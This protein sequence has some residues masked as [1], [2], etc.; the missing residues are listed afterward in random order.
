LTFF[1]LPLLALLQSAGVPGAADMQL[2]RVVLAFTAAGTIVTAVAI[3]LLPAVQLSRGHVHTTVRESA[4]G[5][6]GRPLRRPAREL[7]IAS[8]MALALVLLAGAGLL[9]RSLWQLQH[10][11]TGFNSERVLTFETAVPTATYAEGDQIRFYDRFY[12]RIRALSGVTT[13]GAINILPLSANYDSRGVQIESAPVPAGQ[14]PS[15]QA[16]SI[17]PDYF[18]AMRIRLTEGRFFS[19]S[20]GGN[21]LLVAIVSEAMARRYWPGRSAVGQRITFN[22]GIPRNQQQD[23]GGPGSREVIGVV[24]DVKHLGLDEAEVPMFYTPQAQQPSYHTMTLVVRTT[25]DAASLTSLIRSELARQDPS[26]PLYRA[27]T[28]DEVLLRATAEARMQAWLLGIF[29]VV[30]VVLAAIGVY[31]VIGYV[32]GQRTQEIAVRLALGAGQ[33][34]VL[35]WIFFEGLR[36][37]SLG[38]TAGVL[39]AA[40][41]TRLMA[42]ML[43]EISPTDPVTYTSV[44]ALLLAIACGAVLIPARR[45]A[46]VHPMDAL[47]T[48]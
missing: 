25:T 43:F 41:V 31:G 13:V 15:I 29:A 22:S 5:S 33:R 21:A 42:D 18:R 17:S 44:V 48:D 4:R 30:A 12:D 2:D 38:L 27:R 6:V 20:D 9:L 46:T 3:G 40:G 35:A 26:V 23:V 39:G 10:V 47:R 45:A 34:R 11:D 28:L 32:V 8:Q 37:I 24:G 1:S 16:R 19:N 7:L 36:P 14:S